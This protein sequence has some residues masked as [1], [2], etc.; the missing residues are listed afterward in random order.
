MITQTTF[1]VATSTGRDNVYDAQPALM[2]D[3]SPCGAGHPD[4]WLTL[5]LQ[6][7]REVSC[8]KCGY[9]EEAPG[10]PFEIWQATSEESEPG[11]ESVFMFEKML[12]SWKPSRW[13][14]PACEAR[15]G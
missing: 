5:R 13:S 8:R 14:C 15:P 3:G 1:F 7:M 2:A 10:I 6:A 12:A 9:S 11:P 4:W